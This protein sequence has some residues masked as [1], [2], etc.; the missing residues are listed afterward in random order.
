MEIT[1][2]EEERA[3][4]AYS[5]ERNAVRAMMAQVYVDCRNTLAAY[6]S[7]TARLADDMAQFSDYHLASTAPVQPYIDQLQTVMAAITTIMEGI[8]TAVPDTFG[9]SLPS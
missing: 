3:F 6:A 8:E 2:V 1:T 5:N 4:V 9:I 7:L